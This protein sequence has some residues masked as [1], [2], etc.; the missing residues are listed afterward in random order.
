MSNEFN[1]TEFNSRFDEKTNLGSYEETEYSDKGDSRLLRC[2]QFKKIKGDDGTDAIA[3]SG[4]EIT[5]ECEYFYGSFVELPDEIM[6]LPVIAIEPYASDA[7]SNA[8]TI[9]GVKIPKTI[10]SIGE[11]AFADMGDMDSVEIPETVK[12]IGEYA[13]GYCPAPGYSTEDIY[14]KCENFVIFCSPGSAAEEYA[15]KN[16]FICKPLAE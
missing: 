12:N 15:K 8:V 10:I 6:N 3:I 16:G 11:G 1:Y 7:T 5:D 14:E 9:S 2:F 13:F 4:I